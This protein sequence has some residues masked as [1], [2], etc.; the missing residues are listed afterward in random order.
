MVTATLSGVI[1]MDEARLLSALARR[2]VGANEIELAMT[3]PWSSLADLVPG[4]T[5]TSWRALVM[6]PFWAHR[7]LPA[8]ASAA[9]TRCAED[10]FIAGRPVTEV[11]LLP[12]VVVANWRREADA[13]ARRALGNQ[14]TIAGMGCYADG[15]LRFRS[16]SEVV[17][18]RELR[19]RDLPFMALP[20]YEW[21]GQQREPDFIVVLEGRPYA[22]EIHG[23]PYHPS[24]RTALDYER[25]LIYR[26]AG[27]EVIV[28]DASRV[29]ADPA[30]AVDLLFDIAR[31]GRAA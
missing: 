26:L 18:A 15:G 21:H 7:G 31:L 2:A 16:W 29:R 28:L 30:A 20:A 12:E 24:G 4:G 19:R 13:A 8:G 23:A 14:A 1:E 6:V 3:L 17:F 10:L 22:V 27:I 5:S 25:D 9:A 11:E